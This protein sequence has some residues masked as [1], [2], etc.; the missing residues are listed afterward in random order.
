MTREEEKL[1]FWEHLDIL[2]AAIIKTLVVWVVCSV[3]AFILKDQLFYVVFA[4]RESGFVTYR[5]LESL[6]RLFDM[7]PPGPLHIQLINTGLAQQ[8]IIHMKTALCAGFIFTAPF[9]LFQAFAFVSPALY[10]NERRYAARMVVGGYLMFLVGVALSY[11]VIFPMT[12]QFLGTYQVAADITN[13][14]SLESYMTTL[15]MMCLCM[16]V[17]CELPVLSWM[18]A[19]MGMLSAAFMAEY[20][21]HAIVIILIVAAVITPTSD[22]FT[23]ML[24]SVPVWMLYEVSIL[25]VRRVERQRKS[26]LPTLND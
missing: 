17:V 19:S 7:E 15:I 23:L 3:V 21:R 20:R 9:A 12:F 8:F 24:V 26:D 22:V 5:F 25:L 14:I 11:F 1:S 13:M 2:R 4:P 6:G 16:G 10:T 18:F